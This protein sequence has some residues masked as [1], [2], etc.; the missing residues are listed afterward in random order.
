M[1]AGRFKDSALHLK[2]QGLAVAR[3]KLDLIFG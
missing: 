1:F 2:N 3:E